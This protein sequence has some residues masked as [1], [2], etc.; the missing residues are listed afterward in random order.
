MSKCGICGNEILTGDI[1]WAIGICNNC[2]NKLY[3]SDERKYLDML[4]KET[5]ELLVNSLAEKD[6]Q[7]AELQKQLE[8]KEK[9]L[10][11]IRVEN[12][13]IKSYRDFLNNQCKNL[14]KENKKL[15]R[16]LK[17]QP[18]EILEKIR[19]WGQKHYNWVGDGT[20]YD[21][22]DYNECIGFNKAID[23]MIKML[24]T[25]LKEYQK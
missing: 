7:I 25:I 12:Y 1:H 6:R 14:I 4:H 13:T 17:S 11:E 15:N 9:E 20:G 3:K 19:K 24:D 2:Y 22:Q 16:Q 18:S 10:K 8:E 23:K 21:G 5:G